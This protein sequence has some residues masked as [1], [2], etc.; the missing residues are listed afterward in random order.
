MRML[1]TQV[2]LVNIFHVLLNLIGTLLNLINNC[3]FQILL[4]PLSV[5]AVNVYIFLLVHQLLLLLYLAFFS[6]ALSVWLVS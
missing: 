2:T 5:H 4:L 6:L 1:K 3:N